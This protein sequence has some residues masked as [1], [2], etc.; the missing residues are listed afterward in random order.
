MEKIP[1]VITQTNIKRNKVIDMEKPF[2][3]KKEIHLKKIINT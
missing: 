3:R 1:V 2:I